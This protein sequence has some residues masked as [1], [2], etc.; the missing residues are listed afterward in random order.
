MYFSDP[1]PYKVL[2]K[3]GEFVDYA[4][5]GR[6]VPFKIYYPDIQGIP[7]K[8]EGHVKVPTILWSHGFGGSRDGAS[9]ISRY[10]ASYG[11]N[12][13]HITHDG[14]DS[15]LWEGKPGHPWDILRKAEVSRETTLNRFYDVPFVLDQLL[16]WAAENPEAGAHMDLSRLGMSGHSFGAMTTQVMAGQMFPDAQGALISL[17]E[18]RFKAGILYSPVPIAHLTDEAEHKIYGPIDIPLLHMTGTED[19]SPLH[20]F[21]YEARLAVHVHSGAAEKYLQVLEG[22]D[23]MV[24]AGSRGK[25]GANPLRDEHEAQIKMAALAFWDAQLKDDEAARAWMEKLRV[26]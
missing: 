4:R 20:D 10:L 17:K 3:R 1:G 13:V 23:H 26:W 7:V 18:P 16:R 14:T 6:V 19:S 24:Y 15:S 8:T 12:L 25:L 21:G 22:G 2:L 11:Y 5:G 9:F